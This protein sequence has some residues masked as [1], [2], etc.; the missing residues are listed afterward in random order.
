[1]G[2]SHRQK[3]VKAL[4]GAIRAGLGELFSLPDGYEVALGNGGTTAFWDA[5]AFGLVRERAQHLAF[6]EFSQKFATV[7]KGAPFLGRPGRRSPP[8]RATAPDPAAVGATGAPTCSPGRTTRPRPGSW[9]R[10]CARPAP[11][12]TRWSRSTPPRAPAGCRSTSRQADVYYFAPQKGF[13]SD[14]GLWIALLS[15]AAQERIAELARAPSRWIPEFLSLTTALDN[16]VKDQT[17]NT[18]AV[19]T[20]FLLADQIEWMLGQRRARRRASRARRASSQRA[21]RL[22]GAAA[23]ATPF[24]ADPANRSLVV[25]TIDFDEARRR[26]G[27]RHDA[28]RQRHRR[29]RALPQARPQPAADRHVPGGRAGRRAGADR[30]HRLDRREDRADERDGGG[31]PR[32]ARRRAAARPRQGE[33]RRL[34]AS[35]CCAST[36]TSTSASTGTT[37]SSASGSATTTAS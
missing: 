18:P 5:A 3:P 4:V 10:C 21:L 34:R 14:G 2:T 36:S 13:A 27:R 11:P 26:R 6:G 15:P 22:G 19:A 17:Y 29:H 9:C 35:S 37:R 20:L 23:F 33:D 16:S 32:P 8:S 1:M 31:A 25:G 24:V 28:A 30:L 12:R 7:T